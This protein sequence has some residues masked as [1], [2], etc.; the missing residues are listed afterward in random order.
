MVKKRKKTKNA[1]AKKIVKERRVGKL[2]QVNNLGSTPFKIALTNDT[3]ITKTV[4][5]TSSFKPSLQNAAKINFTAAAILFDS[6]KLSLVYKIPSSNLFFSYQPISVSPLAMPID[7]AKPW[8]NN[9]VLKLGL[10]N[11]SGVLVDGRFS[12]GEGKKSTTTLNTDFFH[13]A[14]SRFGQQKLVFGIDATNFYTTHNNLEFSSRVYFNT[15]TLYRYGYMPENLIYSKDQLL[16]VY[17][18]VGIETAV[19]N[20]H[21]T[22]SGINFNPSIT[23]N[24]FTNNTDARENNLVLKLPVEKILNKTFSV[25][26]AVTADMA[27]FKTP[28]ST[29]KNHLFIV[30]PSFVFSTHNVK[31]QMGLRSGSDNNN[32]SILP[33]IEIV[34]AIPNSNLKIKAGWIGNFV[35]NGFRSIVAF[36]PW[37]SHPNKLINTRISEQFVEIKGGFVNHISL[38]GKLAFQQ[39]NHQSLFLNEAGD[40]KNFSTLF[41]PSI[42]AVKLMGELNYTVQENLSVMASANFTH[43]NQLSIEPFAWGLIPFE[44]TIALHW[45]PLKDLHLNANLFYKKGA[46]YRD[47][48]LTAK[49]LSPAIDMTMGL[50]FTVQPKLNLWIQMNNLFNNTY[51][52]WNQYPVFGFNVLGGV[53]YSFQ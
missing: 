48:G 29:I 36:N 40:G 23:Y 3:M 37:I 43:F 27:D 31:L 32:F 2:N 34:S 49:R 42:R 26:L 12:F 9:H 45:K 18:S 22:S 53:V 7:S 41:E 44:T 6:T 46:M 4:V 11:L 21:I 15:H 33:D 16:L 10:G 13:A 24:R 35:K 47:A 30:N 28:I 50:E 38:N 14:G 1:A 51:Q 5:I 52:R 8:K 19:K 20:I 17:N 25:K 39:I